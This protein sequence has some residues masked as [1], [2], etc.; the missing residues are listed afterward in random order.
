MGGRVN[1]VL[2]QRIERGIAVLDANVTDWRE[3]ID[4]DT[5]S[6]DDI[7]SCVLGQ[8]FGSYLTGAF[9]LGID[10][11]YDEAVAYGFERPKILMYPYHCNVDGCNDF[12]EYDDMTHAWKAMLR[13]EQENAR[14]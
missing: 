5:L 10:G 14:S 13:R 8:V 9:D 6:L 4:L 3:K 11:S 2:R 12:Y 7:E 1:D